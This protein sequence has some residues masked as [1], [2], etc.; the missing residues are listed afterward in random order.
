MPES[1]GRAPPAPQSGR[2]DLGPPSPP[3]DDTTTI[4]NSTI[5]GNGV[6]GDGAVGGVY[7][8]SGLTVIE[9]STITNNTAPDGGGSGVVSLG[10]EEFASTEVL[11]IIISDNP[12]TDV[13]FFSE[14]GTLTNTFLSRGYNLIE[15]MATRQRPRI[16]LSTRRVLPIPASE[17]S[18]T[19]AV[20]PRRTPC[21]RA[22]PP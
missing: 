10:N 6:T 2:R 20:P 21:S 12:G 13:D 11:S 14:F 8:S 15:A 9:H 16:M 5:S 22:V 3:P 4:T 7:N 17:T 19:M 18:P 1:P